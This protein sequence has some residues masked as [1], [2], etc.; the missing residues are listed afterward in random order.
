VKYIVD[1][2]LDR[3]ERQLSI[4]TSHSIIMNKN[5][6]IIASISTIYCASDLKKKRTLTVYIQMNNIFKLV[7]LSW[8]GCFLDYYTCD[9]LIDSGRSFLLNIRWTIHF[10]W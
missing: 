7:T 9:V 1:L 2:T 5:T 4:R 8:L 10:S 6:A 3:K